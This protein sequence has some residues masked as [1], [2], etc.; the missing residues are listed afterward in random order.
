MTMPNLN[1]MIEDVIA[2]QEVD[3]TQES[4]GGAG[5]MPAGYAMARMCTYIEL[6]KQPQEFG[7][8]PKAPA[9]EVRVGFKLFGGPDNCY[10]GRFISTFDLALSNNVKSGAKI[11]FDAL[12]WKNDMKHM[13]QG[14]GRAY[15]VNITVATNATTKKESNRVDIKSVLPP[16]DPVS[17]GNYPVPELAPADYTYFFFD[18]PTK[19]TWD[20]LFVDGEWDDGKSKNKI[21][22]KILASLSFPGSALESMLCNV[23]M[24]DMT[25]APAAPA[26]AAPAAPAAP[27]MP[28][29]PAM[30][31]APVAPA[32]PAMPA[33]PAMP[34]APVTPPDAGVRCVC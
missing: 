5:L 33:M 18:K 16:I 22:E 3:M 7:G 15:L 13:A 11:L 14:L 21:Q 29:A 10:D 27:A 4:T 8:K 26:A 6:G 19:E 12:N 28:T 34:A 23:V 31:A 30:P 1:S 25:P 32:A 9:N 2:T 17:K 24:P 20:A